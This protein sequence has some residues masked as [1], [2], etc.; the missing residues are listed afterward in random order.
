MAKK[1]CVTFIESIKLWWWGI[2]LTAIYNKCA[3]HILNGD[4]VWGE[5]ENRSKL[6]YWSDKYWGLYD[7]LK[8]R[9]GRDEEDE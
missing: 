3:R 8:S 7:S 5:F 1:T 2:R 4:Q 9:S 6:K